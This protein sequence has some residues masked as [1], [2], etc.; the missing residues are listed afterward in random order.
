MNAHSTQ[1]YILTGSNLGERNNYLNTACHL[2]EQKLGA[3]IR[4]SRIYETAA[5]GNTRQPAFLNQVLVFNTIFDGRTLLN[6]LLS[7]EQEMGRTRTLKWA[8]RTIDIDLLLLGNH[9]IR[10]DGLE[11]PHPHMHERRFTLVPMNEVAKEVIHPTL[12][13]SMAQ[14]LSECTDT[15]EVKPW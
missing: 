4:K 9:V 2:L 1:A 8:E 3:A 14:L 13:K 12:H 10:E 6:I 5:W 11:V 15:L 7:T